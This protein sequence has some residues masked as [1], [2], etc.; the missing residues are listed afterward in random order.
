MDL[1]DRIVFVTG[2]ASGIGR[3]LAEACAARG[4]VVIVADVRADRLDRALLEMRDGEPRD[5]ERRVEGVVLDVTDAESF[6]RAIDG[7]VER[8]GRLDILFNNAGIGVTGEARDTTLDAWNRVID[9]NLRGVVHGIDAAYPHMIR[10]GSGHIA[11]TACVAGL[12]PFP[13]T[14]AYSATKHAV[15]GLST[16]LRAEAASLGVRV[17]VICPGVVDTEMFDSIEYL[18]VDKRALLA[19]VDRVM[20]SPDRCARAILRGLARNRPVITTSLHAGL[21]WWLYRLAPRVFLALVTRAFRS[22]RARLRSE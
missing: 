13:M 10:Q 8:H 6:R 18:Q 17:S 19:P 2:G 11:N 15:V 21:V 20:T 14:S 16:A 4:A 5:P 3:A 7:V 12:V 22:L 1:A 9:V